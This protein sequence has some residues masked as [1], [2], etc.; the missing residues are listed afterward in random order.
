MLCLSSA[1]W[2]IQHCCLHA[3]NVCS[4]IHQAIHVVSSK[5]TFSHP[6]HPSTHKWKHTNRGTGVLGWETVWLPVRWVFPILQLWWIWKTSCASPHFPSQTDKQR[7]WFHGMKCLFW[8]QSFMS[9]HCIL[10]QKHVSMFITS[11]QKSLWTSVRFC[12]VSVL[13]QTAM[14]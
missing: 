13:A 5:V 9:L 4:W 11:S 10:F 7:I 8:W 6:A 3:N 2:S 1:S 12:S 14:A